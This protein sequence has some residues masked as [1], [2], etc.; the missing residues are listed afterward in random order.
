MFQLGFH[1]AHDASDATLYLFFYIKNVDKSSVAKYVK[2]ICH[3]WLNLASHVASIKIFVLL[4]CMHNFPFS[5][6]NIFNYICLTNMTG[7]VQIEEAHLV[8]PTYLQG[9]QNNGH[10]LDGVPST[11]F[12]SMLYSLKQKT[13][14]YCWPFLC[15][16]YLITILLSYRAIR[17]FLVQ[18]FSC[19]VATHGHTT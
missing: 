15:L 6:T 1:Y 8:I 10:I 9:N 5:H 19:S 14:N 18:K 17:I 12:S 3:N 2:H 7:C 16:G 11:R 4:I 13:M